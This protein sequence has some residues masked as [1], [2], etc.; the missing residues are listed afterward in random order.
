MKLTCNNVFIVIC[1]LDVKY[2]LIIY[3]E[4]F[5]N[6]LIYLACYWLKNKIDPIFNL[7][8]L[9]FWWIYDFDEL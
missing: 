4:K 7:L 3:Y 9:E 1:T 8:V 2:I 6:L 5:Q